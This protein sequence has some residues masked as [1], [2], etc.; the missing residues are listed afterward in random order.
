VTEEL[1]RQRELKKTDSSDDHLALTLI[2]LDEDLGSFLDDPN[3]DFS[4]EKCAG[5]RVAL[6][7][8]Y[9]GSGSEDREPANLPSHTQD[10]L[11]FLD[12]LC[13]R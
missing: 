5:F 7:H 4:A 13:K 8:S 12:L 1:E 9:T 10:S 11:D 2:G 3:H 6:I